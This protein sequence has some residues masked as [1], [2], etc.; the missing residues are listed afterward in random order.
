[1][2]Q[3]GYIILIGMNLTAC[4]SLKSM[5]N[6]V[7]H[8]VPSH[9]GG[10]HFSDPKVKLKPELPTADLSA[11][12]T[13]KERLKP[14]GFTMG[15]WIART[16][17]PK[18]PS[19]LHSDGPVFQPVVPMDKS[20]AIV[21]L[22]RPD[23]T[24]NFQEIIAP[25]FFLNGERLPGLINNQYYWL[26]LPAGK[27]RLSIR[28][29]VGFVY[30]QKGHTVDFEVKSGNNYYLRYDEQNFRGHPDK[31]LNLLQVG[32]ITQMPERDALKE[33]KFTTLN[34]PGYSFV[35]NPDDTRSAELATF[36]GQSA[37]PV[38][39]SRIE[40]KEKVTL[41]VPLKLWNPTTW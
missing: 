37:K 14:H 10:G 12:I 34:T 7:T 29:P 35:P 6:T 5:G 18:F 33:L 15:A 22:Y 21:Y 3:I 17:G 27:Y 25:S 38:P 19:F 30:F 36:N 24:W 16:D 8:L 9:L 41:G 26:E 2:R 39:N 13:L 32:P 40:T 11:D 4:Q 1:M 28:R 31:S 20:S 23:S